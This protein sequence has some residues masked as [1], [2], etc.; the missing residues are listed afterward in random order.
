MKPI[1]SIVVPVYNAAAFVGKTIDNLLEQDVEKEI[2]LVND[3]STDSSSDILSDY[4]NKYD[5]IKI[6]NKPNGGVSSARNVGIKASIGEYLIFVDSDDLLEC[7]TLKKAIACFKNDIDIVFFSYKHVNSRYEEISFIEYLPTGQYSIKE[8]LD[9]FEKLINSHIVSCIGTKIYK[10]SILK[11]YNIL[12]DENLSHFEDMIFGYDYLLHVNSLYFLNEPLYWYVHINSNSLFHSSNGISS[13]A[14][15]KNLIALENLLIKVYGTTD[16]PYF[17]TY[18]KSLYYPKYNLNL[19]HFLW[20]KI[21]YPVGH[22]VKQLL[23]R[24]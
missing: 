24:K 5:C 20:I 4:S 22:I 12:F 7:G 21:I 16:I 19:M 9:S 14:I 23:L 13:M 1:L 10:S 6:I 15:K 18:T 2:L 11:K 8:W 3:G 17:T